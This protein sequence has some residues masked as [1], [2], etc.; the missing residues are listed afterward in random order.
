[1]LRGSLPECPFWLDPI[2]LH[3]PDLLYPVG[4]VSFRFRLVTSS[5]AF[6]KS[7]TSNLLVD[8]PSIA[9]FNKAGR[10]FLFRHSLSPFT[11]RPL[12]DLYSSAQV[13]RSSR[14]KPIPCSPMGISVRCGLTS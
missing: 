10:P 6:A 1:M 9:P 13:S 3:L 11:R 12:R 2:H 14:S 5:S 7:S 4:E 8:M